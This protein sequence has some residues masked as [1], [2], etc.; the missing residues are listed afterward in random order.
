MDTPFSA[1]GAVAGA[2]AVGAAVDPRIKQKG[3]GKTARIPIKIVPIEQVL[4]KPPW[5]RAKPPLISS[6]S[7]ACT[8]RPAPAPTTSIRSG[9]SRSSSSACPACPPRPA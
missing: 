3:Q 6:R 9:C 5:I 4:K 1:P 7:R 2:S 8:A